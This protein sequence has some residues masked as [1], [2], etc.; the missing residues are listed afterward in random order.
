VSEPVKRS[1]SSVE[2]AVAFLKVVGAQGEAGMT[3]SDLA[4]AVGQPVSTCHRY[5]TTMVD[6]GLFR[7][8]QSGRLFLGAGLIALALSALSQDPLR[9]LAHP[10]LEHLSRLSG[11]TVHLGRHGAQGV[12]YVDKL[13]SAHQVRLVSRVGAVV[14][15]YCTAMGKAIMATLPAEELAALEAVATVKRT[16]RTLVG[17]ALHREVEA[18]R[19][20]GWAVDEQENEEGVR[21]VGA[22]IMSLSGDLLG[23]VSVS[24]PATRFTREACDA[25]APEV[26][27]SARRIGR[28]ES[29]PD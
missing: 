8:D 15:H 19:A 5:V 17:P 7:R 13:D 23:A 10:H 14:P 24:G 21:C 22:A 18:V 4:G 26:L 1:S 29:V 28:G 3:L 9:V 27:A 12:L 20:Q 11:E 25:I 16:D 6:Q 2:R